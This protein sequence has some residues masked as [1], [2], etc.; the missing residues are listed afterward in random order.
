MTINVD[1]TATDKTKTTNL[2]RGIDVGNA[3]S[4][5]TQ[6][7][8]NSITCDGK[9]VQFK[10]RPTITTFY[11]NDDAKMLTYDS[12]ADGHYLSKKHRNKLGPP[13]LRVSA[14]RV[15]VANGGACNGK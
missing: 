11:N 8:I 9:H 4:T 2:Q 3:I 14:K 6:R 5:E 12:G 7:L 1:Y 13:I 10:R 15:G